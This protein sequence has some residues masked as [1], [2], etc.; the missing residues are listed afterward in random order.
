M[1]M[2]QVL[3]I[4]TVSVLSLACMTI[5][6][7]V[8]GR[9]MRVSQV[10]P[11]YRCGILATEEYMG[12]HYCVICQLVVVRMIGAVRQDPPFGFPG[13]SGYLQFPNPEKKERS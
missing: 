2:S 12:L 5:V 9:F 13:A 4:L 1:M 7:I 11:C 10:H 3:F 6:A 8:V